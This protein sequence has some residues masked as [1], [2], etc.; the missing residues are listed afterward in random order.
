MHIDC[1][2]VYDYSLCL[3]IYSIYNILQY[4]YIDIFGHTMDL[5]MIHHIELSKDNWDNVSQ[6]FAHLRGLRLKECCNS[7]SAEL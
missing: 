6:I 4:D 3:Y 2:L 7:F 5:I 1:I